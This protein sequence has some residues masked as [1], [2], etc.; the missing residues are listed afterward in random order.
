MNT[1]KIITDKLTHISDQ[2]IIYLERIV[3]EED[4]FK[5]VLKQNIK[6]PIRGLDVSGRRYNLVGLTSI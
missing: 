4:G 3:E 1:E 2:L 5:Q 6:F